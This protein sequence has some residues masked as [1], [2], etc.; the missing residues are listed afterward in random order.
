MRPQI[1]T[2]AAYTAAATNNIALAQ[3]PAA[4]GQQNLV[5]NGALATGGVATLDQPRQVSITFA[6]AD[7]ARRIVVIGTGRKGNDKMETVQG[8][9][10]GA[11]QT[12]RAFK[13]V[14]QIIIDANSA[15]A[16]TVGTTTIVDTDWYPV[17]YMVSA[18]AMSLM[19]SGVSTTVGGLF[20]VQWTNNRLGWGGSAE[21]D[22][23]KASWASIFDRF[24]PSIKVA[25]HDTLVNIAPA[26]ADPISSNIVVPVTAIRLRSINV[27]TGGPVQLSFAQTL[28][29]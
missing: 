1:L 19:L 24:F 10:A 22:S 27:F 6:G 4:G 25:N 3:T 28:G 21:F 18:F 23:T 8:A 17:D 13:T 29:D 2:I 16:I 7:A 14:R 9:N 5:I 26:A 11:V 20:S 12:I 15:G